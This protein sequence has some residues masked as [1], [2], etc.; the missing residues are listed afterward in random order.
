MKNKILIVSA[1]VCLA[2]FSCKFDNSKETDNTKKLEKNSNMKNPVR[3]FE[4]PV[5][6]MERAIQ[7][8]HGV[9]GFDF[10]KDT[11]DGNEM[12]FFPQ[13]ENGE[14]ISGA[15][16]KGR[17]YKP[18]KNGTLVY[19]D[20]ENIE[21]TLLKVEENSGKILYPKTAIGALGFVAEFEDSE[22]NRIAL[23]QN[24]EKCWVMEERSGDEKKE[25]Q[26]F[27][28]SQETKDVVKEED[29]FNGGYRYKLKFAFS[30][31]N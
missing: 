22:G 8:Y 18:S 7:F 17:T 28:I 2:L 29:F 13:V 6:N 16:A 27:W 23:H 3:Y 19:F 9:F 10:E 5:Q 30:E 14:G 24:K 15:L 21:K 31:T 25:Y 11:I 12:A 1:C 20:S 26:R 4:I